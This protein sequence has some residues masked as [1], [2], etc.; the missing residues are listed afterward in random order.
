MRPP[1][2]GAY[3]GDKGAHCNV[4][5]PVDALALAHLAQS[6]L[7]LRRLGASARR[8]PVHGEAARQ[9]P[10]EVLARVGPFDPGVGMPS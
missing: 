10:V 1:G 3:L 9:P 6:R 8:Q 7:N 5:F 2:P 4:V